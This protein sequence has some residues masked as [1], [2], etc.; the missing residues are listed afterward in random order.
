MLF[1]YIFTL[2]L[3]RWSLFTIVEPYKHPCFPSLLLL[4]CIR[5]S[6]YRDSTLLFSLPFFREKVLPSVVVV[7][8]S[9]LNRSLPVSLRPLRN[10]CLYSRSSRVNQTFFRVSNFPLIQNL[11]SEVNVIIKKFSPDRIR[12][13]VDRQKCLGSR[14]SPWRYVVEFI[15]LR[16]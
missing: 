16:L 5:C 9:T 13:D 1:F 6:C 8:M 12:S 15:T 11:I 2:I 4:S 3:W 14:F 7:I 10:D